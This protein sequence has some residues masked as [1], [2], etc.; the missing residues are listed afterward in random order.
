LRESWR[1]IRDKTIVE[2]R[3]DPRYLARPDGADIVQSVELQAVTTNNSAVRFVGYVHPP[4]T[5][6]YEFWLSGGTSAVLYMS[7]TESPADEVR[8][9]TSEDN[10][11]DLDK[12]RF[13]GPSPWAPPMRL[14]AGRRYYIE[15]IVL[16]QQG[17]GH[18]SVAWRRQGGA[19]ELLTGEFLSP[20]KPKK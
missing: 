6:D 13:Q 12:P 8:V 16:I 20:Y 15:A 10:S 14:V 2:F 18:L 19:R 1:G 17:E 7:P 11:R 3:G 9:A 5:G 4:A